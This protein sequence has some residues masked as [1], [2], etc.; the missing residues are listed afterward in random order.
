MK[1]KKKDLLKVCK[2]FLFE[3]KQKVS[4][5]Y[6]KNIDKQTAI[7]HDETGIEYTVED[8]DGEEILTV[9]RHDKDEPDDKVYDQVDHDLFAKDYSLV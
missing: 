2:L 8:N 4:K 3:K 7:R 1:I 5:E 6:I 9:Y